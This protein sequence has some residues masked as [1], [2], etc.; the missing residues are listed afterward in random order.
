MLQ[1]ATIT[2]TD[3]VLVAGCAPGYAAAIVSHLAGDVVTTDSDRPAEG[4]A[5]SGPYDVIVLDGATEIVPEDLYR[6]L[7]IGGRLVGVFALSAPARATLVTRSAADYGSRSLFDA[8][9]PVLPGLARGSG[10]RILR[11]FTA[12]PMSVQKCGLKD[13]MG[14]EFQVGGRRGL[15]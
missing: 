3:K 9:A 4:R 12:N 15:T 5:G 6:Q 11:I 13:P 1:A 2:A 14:G 7:K 10:F 8:T